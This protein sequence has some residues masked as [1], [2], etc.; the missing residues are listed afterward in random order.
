M[1]NEVGRPSKLDTID[2][3]QVKKLAKHGLTEEQI[4]DILGI[5]KATITNYKLSS[6]E[7]LASL[8]EGKEISDLKVEKSLFQ[9]A[10]GYEHPEEEIFCNK[11]GVVTTVPTMK[12]Y[13][14]DTTACIFWLKNRKKAEWRDTIEHTGDPNNPIQIN[15]SKTYKDKAV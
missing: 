7:F 5:C 4:A 13:P 2:L 10:V 12:F 9:R 3:E 15:I 6:P 1:E 8:K 14:P 11:D